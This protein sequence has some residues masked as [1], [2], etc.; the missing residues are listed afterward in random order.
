MQ[1]SG[2]FRLPQHTTDNSFSSKRHRAVG[3]MNSYAELMTSNNSTELLQR[4]SV[5]R[6]AQGDEHEFVGPPLISRVI[7]VTRQRPQRLI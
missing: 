4:K 3:E 5:S 7:S 6:R 2:N 1:R